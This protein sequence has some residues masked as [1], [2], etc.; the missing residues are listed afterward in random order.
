MVDLERN[1]L[2]EAIDRTKVRLSDKQ[3]IWYS[4]NLKYAKTGPVQVSD[5]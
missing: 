4:M 3:S 1:V 2:L 5:K